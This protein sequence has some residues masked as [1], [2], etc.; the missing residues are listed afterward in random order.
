[1]PNYFDDNPSDLDTAAEI[2]R[3]VREAGGDPMDVDT[4]NK[5]TFGLAILNG[6]EDDPP[7][8]RENAA[9]MAAETE[10]VADALENEYGVDVEEWP[11]IENA[12]SWYDGRR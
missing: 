7:P 2:R 9:V 10:M 3:A 8:S 11:E 1:M 6:W 4:E 12:P 5:A